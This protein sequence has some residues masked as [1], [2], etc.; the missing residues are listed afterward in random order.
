EKSAERDGK[1]ERL[2]KRRGSQADG[3]G[4]QEENLRIL[5]EARPAE[6]PGNDGDCKESQRYKQQD[7]FSERPGDFLEAAFSGTVKNGKDNGHKNDGEVF[8]ERDANH[9]SAVSRPECAAIGQQ[10]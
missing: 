7:S 5:C 1:T 6:K 8:D 10:A 3:D 4:D 9:D 2:G